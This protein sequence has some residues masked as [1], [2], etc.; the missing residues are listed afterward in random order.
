MLRD[1]SKSRDGM[2]TIEFIILLPIFLL[3]VFAAIMAIH[4]TLVQMQL[5]T[6]LRTIARNDILNGVACRDG[7]SGNAA[8]FKGRLCSYM[9]AGGSCA[10]DVI[11]DV[12][13]YANAAAF[14]AS[15]PPSPLNS[16]GGRNMAVDSVF[17]RMKGGEFASIRAF[18]VIDILA[19][20]PNIGLSNMADGSMMIGS[21]VIYTAEPY[22]NC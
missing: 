4:T 16:S 2:A 20:V 19:A 7:W 12:R 17:Q 21:T 18:Y 14:V 22:G 9:G 11:I 13:A 15:P 5:D 8:Q 10:S 6:G 3:I 1:F